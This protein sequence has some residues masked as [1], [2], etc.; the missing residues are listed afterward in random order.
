MRLAKLKRVRQNQ[1][2]F[3][4][5]KSEQRKREFQEALRKILHV[6]QDRNSS[7]KKVWN[8]VLHF[9]DNRRFR[10]SNHTPPKDSLKR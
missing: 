10:V 6:C 7:N 4:L 5:V 2:L 1:K 3:H 8:E 9:L